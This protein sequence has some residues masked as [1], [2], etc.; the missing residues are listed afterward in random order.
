MHS[1][2]YPAVALSLVSRSSHTHIMGSNDEMKDVKHRGNMQ[3]D[4]FI[5]SMGQWHHLLL[6]S[7]SVSVKRAVPVWLPFPST[8]HTGP[9]NLA[10]HHVSQSSK[11]HLCSD[12]PCPTPSPPQLFPSTHSSNTCFP[13]LPQGY[14][15]GSMYPPQKS[16]SAPS[17]G[18]PGPAPPAG[19]S[20]G[21][22]RHPDFEKTQPPGKRLSQCALV[23]YVLYFKW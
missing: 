13:S 23:I 17:P 5:N 14:Q 15:G 4:R 1:S 2:G 22:R 8:P 20:A 19:Y 16:G 7:H 3:H 9:Y 18:P 10:R 21:P 12:G 11:I 6:N